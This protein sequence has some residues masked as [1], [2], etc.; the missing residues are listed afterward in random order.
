[1]PRNWKMPMGRKKRQASGGRHDDEAYESWRPYGE[2]LVGGGDD[3]PG[4]NE[5]QLGVAA[6]LKG[7]IK[8]LRS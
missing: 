8:K 4:T 1:M 7:A 2:D 6:P 5:P 3:F